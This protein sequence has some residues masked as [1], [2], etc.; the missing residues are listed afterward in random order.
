M[1]LRS[2]AMPD[3]PR[4]PRPPVEEPR[5]PAPAAPAAD[6]AAQPAEVPDAGPWRADR[7][8]TV[9][10]IIG[11]VVFVV[12]ALIVGDPIGRGLLV[13]AAVVCA[14]Y[15]ARDLLV[16]VRV[17]ADA[18][19]LTVAHGYLGHARLPWSAVERVAVDRR[20]RLGLRSE[21]LEI[22]AGEQLFLFSSYDLSAEPAHVAA[23]L[24]R[25]RT[26]H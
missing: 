14:L 16:P 5:P 13:L 15:A 24:A 20:S 7:R 26:G 19:G 9:F 3:E 12:A 22:D 4:K 25:I 21:M 11:L 17:A 2:G 6:E 8:L 23:A 1:E 10:K 18:E